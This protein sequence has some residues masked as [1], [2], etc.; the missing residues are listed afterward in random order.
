MRNVRAFVPVAPGH[1][2]CHKAGASLSFGEETPHTPSLMQQTCP[3]TC[4]H[5]TASC[6]SRQTE[7]Q[8]DTLFIN[9][10]K[11]NCQAAHEKQQT[12]IYENMQMPACVRLKATFY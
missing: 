9:K 3:L 12:N 10:G 8:T 5:W 4:F 2:S 6:G 1:C 7:Q 11:F